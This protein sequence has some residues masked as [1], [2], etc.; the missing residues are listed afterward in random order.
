MGNRASRSSSAIRGRAILVALVGVVAFVGASCAPPPTTFNFGPFTVPLPPIGAQATPVNYEVEIPGIPPIELTPYVAP[1][2]LTPYIAPVELT[3][4]IP[5]V[6]LT[7]YIPE[8]C[9]PFVG[10][11]PAVPATYSPAVPAT[12]SP[13]IPATYSPEIPATYSPAI[14]GGSCN[15][16]YTPPAFF[17]NDITADIPLVSLDLAA[18]TVTIPNVKVNIPAATLSA[19]S[20]SVGCSIAGLPAV[21]LPTGDVSITFPAQAV[22]QDATLDLATGILTLSNPSFSVTGVG[23]HFAGLDADF[24]LPD[25][26]I[27]LP[28]ITVPLT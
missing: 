2:Q 12:Y 9:F 18:A 16:G 24:S 8:V 11:T 27:P 10:C 13:A 5:P 15:A 14:P 23:L 17:I 3:P 19:G 20:A 1:V 25:I 22:V 21:N 4:Y 7:P 26:A 6:Q 28:T